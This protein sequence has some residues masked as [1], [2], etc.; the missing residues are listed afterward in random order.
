MFQLTV[1]CVHDP[2]AEMPDKEFEIP[3]DFEYLSKAEA[4]ALRW[5]TYRPN[6]IVMLHEEE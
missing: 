1:L 6:D 3:K 4:R 2:K 5:L